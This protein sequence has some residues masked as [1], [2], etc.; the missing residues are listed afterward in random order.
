MYI[1]NI[2]RAI[3]NEFKDFEKCYKELDVLRKTAIIQ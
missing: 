1:L 2:A 3:K